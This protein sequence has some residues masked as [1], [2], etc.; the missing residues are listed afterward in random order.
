MGAASS[1]AV[2]S[3]GTTL[4]LLLLVRVTRREVLF[5]FALIAEAVAAQ[6]SIQM[7]GKQHLGISLGMH[8]HP[9]TSERIW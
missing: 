4:F 8:L 9:L 2:I 7:D 1:V 5:A 6:K 3:D